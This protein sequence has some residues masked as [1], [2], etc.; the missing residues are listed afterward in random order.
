MSEYRLVKHRG[1]WSLAYGHPRKRIATGANDRGR[2]EL[3]A[4]EIWRRINRPAQERVSDLWTPYVQDRAP[5]GKARKRMDSL[6]K[7]L[8]PTSGYKLGKALITAHSQKPSL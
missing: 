7:Q 3:I 5:E 6:W 4:G 2:A 1:Q 8:E